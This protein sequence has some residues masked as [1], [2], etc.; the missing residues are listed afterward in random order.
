MCEI[1]QIKKDDL[2][3]YS[4]ALCEKLLPLL[5]KAQK[6][7]CSNITS[8]LLKTV[9]NEAIE[10]PSLNNKYLQKLKDNPIYEAMKYCAPDLMGRGVYHKISA[11]LDKANNVSKKLESAR[12]N[13][14][15]I[16]D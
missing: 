16:K 6:A 8:E 15:Q 14:S 7:G 9:H 1:G 11:D 4:A 12:K 10:I 2:V 5:E 3:I 13:S